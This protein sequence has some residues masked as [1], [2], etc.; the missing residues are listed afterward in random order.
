M[1]HVEFIENK[2]QWNENIV[3][4][5]QLPAGNLYLEKNALTYLFYNERDIDRLHEL[6]HHEIKNPTPQDYIM[7]LHAFKINFLNAHTEKINA[8]QP[9]P[10]YVNYYLGNDKEKWA[11]NV[12]KYRKTTYKNIYDSVDLKF[13]LKESFLKY[14]F[15]VAPGGNPYEIQLDYEGVNNLVLEKGALKISTSVNEIIEQKPYA[16]QLVNGIKKKVKCNFK[17]DG[18][19]VSFEFPKGYN[20]NKKLIIDPTLVFA[21]YSGSTVDNWGYTSTF[22]DEGHLY[23]GGATFGVGYPTTTGA[24]QLNFAGGTSLNGGIDITITK[25]TPDGTAL[26]YST[27]LGGAGNESPHSLIVNNNHELIIL[28]TTSS[29][30]FPVSTNGYDTTYAGGTPY[31]G[32]TPNYTNGSDIIISKLDSLGTTLTG[33]T[34]IGGTGNDGLNTGANL[35]KNYADEFRGEIIIDDNNNIYVASSTSS[36]DFPT[37]GGAI[38]SSLSGGQDG[39]TFKLSPDLTTLIWSTYL[40]GTNDDAAYSLQ[41]D[42]FDNVVITG[43]TKSTDF[44]IMGSSYQTTYQGG[45]TDGWIARI[46]NTATF[47]LNSTYIGTSAYDQCYFVQLDT[48]DNVY[49]IGQ[50]EGTYPITP[51]TVHNNPN[52]GQFI[53]KLTPNL[54]NTVFSTTFGTSSG[55]IDIALSA[56]LVNE[57]NYILISGWG[58]TVNTGNG[59][60]PMSTTLGLPV[61]PNAIQPITDGNDY[62]LTMFNENA[63]SLLFATF[64]GGNTSSDHVDGGTSRFDKKGI[65]YQ[66]VC[67]SCG[68]NNTGDF[69][70]TTGAH[71][72]TN[73][74]SNCNLGVFKFDLSQLTADADVYTTPYYCVGD[75]VHFQNLSNG[76]VTFTWDFGDGSPNSNAV[77]PFHTFNTS[78]T[79]NVR[80]IALDAVSCIFQ[81]TDYVDVFIGAPP[82]AS[83]LPINGICPGDS[84]IINISGGDSSIWIT[85]Y[86]ILND[87]LPTATVWPDTSMIYAGVTFN[88]CGSDTSEVLVTVFPNNTSITA[89][90]T[91]CNNMSLQIV[92]SGGNNYLWSPSGTLNNPNIANP[93]ATPVVTTTYNVTITD[94]NTCVWD[95][96]MTIT[97]ISLPPIADAGRDTYVCLGDSVQLNATGGSTY[98]WDFSPS[99]S[100]P[101]I[102]DPYVYPTQNTE[103]SLEVMNACGVNRDTV[104]VSVSIVNAR[105]WPDTTVCS[106][107]EIQLFS[108]GGSVVKWEP[109][110]EV[111]QTLNG[112]FTAP[113]QST[114]YTVT[115]ENTFGCQADTFINVDV[116][117]LPFLEAGGDQWANYN[118]LTL[119]A[120]GVGTF[121]WSPSIFL[122]CD[123]C[124][125]TLALPDQTTTYTVSLRDSAGCVNTDELTIFVPAEIYAPNAFTPNGDDKNELFLLKTYQIDKF[126]LQIFNRWGQLLF[127]TED[128]TKGWDGYYKGVLSKNDVYIWKVKYTTLSGERDSMNGTVTLVR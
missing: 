47:L 108:S 64:F 2:G 54:S 78:G 17:L 29:N 71:S 45:D 36:N 93:T 33:S 106:T 128:K 30:N 94:V 67:A 34:Y 63:D 105:A 121:N 11:S 111:Y 7:N 122:S 77:E 53:H 5:A 62:Y 127:Q 20:K 99:M 82:I 80:L 91:I 18:T 96:F 101:N 15:V 114:T 21:S 104:L 27:Y 52:S 86:N 50:T 74:S 16:Y 19:T 90:T 28:G 65:V 9:S 109:Q 22:D 112:N 6:H 12:K 51:S 115:I 32:F 59:G 97:T 79:Y 43:G 44:P 68:L 125:K 85:N 56:F 57:C 66:A 41:F 46:N 69:P 126:Y 75:N 113:T 38:Q 23:G 26:I 58:G 25:F 98:D 116:N 10:D 24:F 88:R 83:T 73:N 110:N 120:T 72:S 13:Y 117:P 123:T 107:Q 4:K 31:T 76:G 95:T 42:S 48:A 81:D 8:T 119:E 55:E 40:G 84:L 89:D 60:P 92:A 39:C 124:Q 87:T 102:A 49:V 118:N 37:T 35:K 14:D 103:Y 3:Y 100:N 70:V 1:D 61:T